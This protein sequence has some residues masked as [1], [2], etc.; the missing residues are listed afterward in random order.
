MAC[1][2]GEK[3]TTHQI[4]VLTFMCV[5]G[6]KDYYDTFEIN[7]TH[8]FGWMVK[9]KVKNLILM[10]WSLNQMGWDQVW[11]EFYSNVHASRRLSSTYNVGLAIRILLCSDILQYFVTQTFKILGWAHS[12]ETNKSY[13]WYLVRDL[14]FRFIFYWKYDKGPGKCLTKSETWCNFFKIIVI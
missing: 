9:N 4:F 3:S 7:P 12:I 1:P 5:G 8:T 10:W 6:K 11:L 13:H 2:W 14:S